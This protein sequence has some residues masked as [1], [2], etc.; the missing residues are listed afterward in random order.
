VTVPG[1]AP[2]DRPEDGG[3]VPLSGV[4]LQR[5]TS[6]VAAAGVVHD[7]PA[8]S[9]EVRV[10]GG[11]DGAVTWHVELEPGAPPRYIAG[12]LPEADA[13]YDQSW[14]DAV[15]QFAGRSEP[16]VGFMQGTLKVKGATRP[17]YELFRLW[18]QPAHRAATADLL[19][20]H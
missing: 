18:A 16:V 20:G 15:E 17:L 3:A 1:T 13:S 5:W 9:V 11:P 8:G 12:P 2:A 4:L 14:A 10:S 7:G 19:A 6:A